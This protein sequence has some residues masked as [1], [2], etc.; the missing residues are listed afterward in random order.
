MTFFSAVGVAAVTIRDCSTQTFTTLGFRLEYRAD[1]LACVARVPFVEQILERRQLIVV[2]EQRVVVIV[3]SD[4][5]D[6]VSRKYKLSVV[7]DLDIVS[8]EP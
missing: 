4:I 7:A 5:P 1:F 2:A 6:A 3:D 8:A